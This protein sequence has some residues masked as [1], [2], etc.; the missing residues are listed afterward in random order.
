MFYPRLCLDG[1]DDF[2]AALQGIQEKLKGEEGDEETEAELI[3]TLVGD[4]E[5]GDKIKDLGGLKGLLTEL[6]GMRGKFK[7]MEAGHTQ[8]TQKLS[9]AEKRF[10]ELGTGSFDNFLAGG[11]GKAP[12]RKE[13]LLGL[14]EKYKLDPKSHPFWNDLAEIVTS[15]DQ[16]HE[17]NQQ[18]S[19]ATFALAAAL[20][21]SVWKHQLRTNEKY[22]G[23]DDE[24]VEKLMQDLSTDENA[25]SVFMQDG[26]NPLENLYTQNFAKLHPEI[27][28][29]K[30]EEKSMGKSKEGSGFVETPGAGR[31]SDKPDAGK[32]G[33]SPDQIAK[34]I[35]KASG[36]QVVMP[37]TSGD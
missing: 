5:G 23:V 7:D 25:L 32:G 26:K 12:S 10:A 28:E 35:E 2:S 8:A 33:R 34:E 29:K 36:G 37:P 30:I 11:G 15:S 21:R 14:M 9:A 18:T 27:I 16:G 22:K 3:Q 20:A 4:I 13:R 6:V 19:Q 31:V 1:V 24:T 17:K